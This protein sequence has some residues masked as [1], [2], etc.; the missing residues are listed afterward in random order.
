MAFATLYAAL[1]FNSFLLSPFLIAATPRHCF[2][3]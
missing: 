3:A 2:D 1:H